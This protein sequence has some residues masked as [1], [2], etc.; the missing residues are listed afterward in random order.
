[1]KLFLDFLPIV[2]FFVTFKWAGSDPQAAQQALAPILGPMAQDSLDTQQLPI[3]AATLVAILAT[4]LQ[5]V[6]QKVTRKPV[7]RMQWIGLVIILSTV[8]KL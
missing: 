5:V 3:L 6:Y 7:E 2:L 8:S 4:C 1:M